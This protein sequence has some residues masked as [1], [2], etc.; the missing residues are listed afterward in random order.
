MIWQ[1]LKNY[2]IFYFCEIFITPSEELRLKENHEIYMYS[3]CEVYD[4][5]RCRHYHQRAVFQRG[6]ITQDAV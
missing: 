6:P 5:A 3:F 4:V 1:N 2:A